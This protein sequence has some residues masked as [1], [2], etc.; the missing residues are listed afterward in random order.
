M[1]KAI[2]ISLAV[3]WLYPPLWG[4]ILFCDLIFLALWS[5]WHRLK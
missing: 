3:Y 1:I 5:E 4:V 2:L